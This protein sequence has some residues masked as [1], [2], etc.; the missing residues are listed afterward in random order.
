MTIF[1]GV[2]SERPENEDVT[3]S[4]A[5]DILPAASWA[6]RVICVVPDSGTPVMVQL[7]VPVAVPVAPLSVAQ[8]TCVTATSSDAVPP[9]L[10]VLPEAVKLPADVGEVMAT[11]G[12][13]VSGT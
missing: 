7:E 9:R 11:A 1:G 6:V 10:I 2:V 13:V 3:V 4:K 5:L 8:V 12:G